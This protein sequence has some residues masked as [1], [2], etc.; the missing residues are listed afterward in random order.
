MARGGPRPGVTLHRF[1]VPP[2]AVRHDEVEFPADLSRQIDRVLRLKSGDQVLV[3]DGTGTEHTVRLELVGR[4]TTGS[5]VL[6]TR[7]LA[8]P[9]IR[10]TLYQGLI[11]GTKLELVLQKCTEVGVSRFVPMTTARAVPTGP[12]TSRQAR[13]E[14][15][16]REAA[17]QSGRGQIPTVVPSAPFPEALMDAC[18]A[19]P[20]V[21]LW[22]ESRG[23]RLS[24]VPRPSKGAGVSL[25][26]GP[27]GGFSS[28]EAESARRAGA[29]VVTLGPRILRAETAA[30]VGSAILLDRW[31]DV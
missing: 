27:E 3:L 18:R 21:F 2:G 1:F 22:E 17:E 6:H 14:T 13:F 11:K 9:A 12:S 24:D 16:V 20:V 30:I 28:D 4:V 8:E 25:F 26:V 19:G 10:L 31:D 23:V 5:V 15:I 7:N 29:H